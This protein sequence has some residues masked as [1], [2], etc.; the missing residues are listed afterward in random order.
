MAGH[1]LILSLAADTALAEVSASDGRT[2]KHVGV[3]RRP[4]GMIEVPVGEDVF[5]AVEAAR[6]PGESDSDVILR[7]AHFYLRKPLQ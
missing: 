7:L 6:V 4:D 5:R 3:T 2:M 1:V